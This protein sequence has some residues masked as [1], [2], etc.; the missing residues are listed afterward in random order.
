MA[1][2]GMMDSVPIRK[3]RREFEDD[4]PEPADKVRHDVYQGEVTVLTYTTEI[5][6][7][8]QHTYSFHRRPASL[9]AKRCP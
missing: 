1:Q 3:R 8:V 5:T 6:T 7:N 4:V 9:A 2:P